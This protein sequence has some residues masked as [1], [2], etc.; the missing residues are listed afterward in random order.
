[1]AM[2]MMCNCIGAPLLTEGR[3]MEPIPGCLGFVI[4]R[5]RLDK[6]GN[7]GPTEI[8]RNRVG[9]KDGSNNDEENNVDDQMLSQPSNIWPFQSFN[10]TDHGANS[11]ANGEIQDRCCFQR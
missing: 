1:M 9:F 5:Q 8:L 3:A 7:F 10:W 4:E 2:A 11:G 6:H